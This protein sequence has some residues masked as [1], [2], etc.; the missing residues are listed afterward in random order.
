MNLYTF[1]KPFFFMFLPE[2][3]H[4]L[5]ITALKYGL[6]P[7]S[8]LPQN[9]RLSQTLWGLNFKNPV[10]LAAGFDKN[11]EVYKPMLGQGFGFV[12]TG[13]VTPLAQPGNEQPRIFRL[14]EDQAVINRMGFNNKGL[15]YYISQLQKRDPNDG[16]VGA[17]IGAN[18]L[19]EDPINDYVIGLERVLGLADYFTINIS[20]PNTPGLRKLQGREALDELLSKL[21]AVRENAKLE[22]EPP[23]ILKIAPD[24]DDQECEDIADI[25]LKHEMDGLIVS[26]TTL[27]RDGLTSDQKD[28]AGG[29]SGKPL[30]EFS[31]QVLSKMYKLTEG[32]IPLIGVGGVSNGEEAYAKIRA[33]ASLVQLYSALVYHGPSLAE[34]INLELNELL[35]KDGFSNI[36]E[37][38]GIDHK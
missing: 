14:T 8:N 30:F 2:Q 34:K 25:I 26:N 27:S 24:L 4:T 31:T 18:K 29:M 35:R 28:E 37:A 3:A 6:I 33:G 16:I 13:T 9:S 19:S 22:K 1:A 11:A 10:G 7:G 32:K 38:T 5:A 15:D 21:K 36:T 20:S 12:E 23:L 17:N